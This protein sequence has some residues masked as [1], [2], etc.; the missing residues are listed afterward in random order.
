MGLVIDPQKMATEAEKI[1]AR[2]KD[3]LEPEHKGQVVAIDVESGDFFLGEA[4]IEAGQGGGG[5]GTDLL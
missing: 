2:I 5:C 4:V 3:E 1:Y